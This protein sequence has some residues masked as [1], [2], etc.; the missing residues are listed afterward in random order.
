M[1]D[2][3][4]LLDPLEHD[5]MPDRWDSIRRRPVTPLPERHRSRLPVFAVVL[6]VVALTVSLVGGLLPLADE[7]GGGGPNGGTAPPAWLAE[8]AYRAAYGAGDMLP[9]QAEWA[10]LPR[11]AIPTPVGTAGAG[12][13]TQEYVIVLRG[14]FTAYGAS[15]PAGADLPTGSVL[16]IAY[17]ASTHDV[18][19]LSV[20]DGDPGIAGL[21][22]FALPP[23]GSLF[24]AAT[25][26]TAAIPPGWKTLAGI[27]DWSGG[28]TEWSA[29]TK[30]AGLISIVGNPDLTQVSADG[31]P[32][33]GVA[34]VVAPV[35]SS[36]PQPSQPPAE[37]PLSSA[38]LA[39]GSAPGGASTLD[40]MYFQGGDS[41]YSLT[42]R[43]GPD[44]SVLDR[45]AVEAVI[46]SITWNAQAVTSPPPAPNL[47]VPTASSVVDGR[48]VESVAL[49]DG[50]LR[51]DPPPADM[52]TPDLPRDAEDRLWASPTFQFKDAVTI[53]FGLITLNV[54]FSE[55]GAI[56]EKPG[57]IAFAQGGA[58]CGMTTAPSPTGFASDGFGAVTF[59]DNGENFS[60]TAVTNSC[61]NGR[62]PAVDRA[63]HVLSLPWEQLGPVTADG[64]VT[65]RYPSPP[66]GVDPVVTVSVNDAG[67]TKIRVDMTTFNDPL[68]CPSPRTLTSNVQLS[69]D[70]HGDP[71]HDRLGI[72]QQAINVSLLQP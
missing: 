30:N 15:V 51:V 49:D 35:G 72:V 55:I 28:G 6:A 37:L 11:S 62:D 13:S 8:A 33:D 41:V 1:P 64:H 2:L 60:Y 31:F 22:P 10:L 25:G 36:V 26:W 65:I 66:C 58:S 27:T 42:V 57:W 59:I 38:D 7:T 34:L 16:S 9:D 12:D 44:A 21:Q 63:R 48:F 69:P 39:E 53:G 61:G 71:A 4:H 68:P 3:K 67:F 52:S 50:L 23:Q 5:E 45:A 32:D 19:D 56:Q 54:P 29:I 46:G 24:R 70:S 18:T 17:D 43:T 20:G 40:S 47:G 14:H